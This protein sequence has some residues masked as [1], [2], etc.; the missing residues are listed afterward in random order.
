[1]FGARLIGVMRLLRTGAWSL[2]PMVSRRFIAAAASSNRN[3]QQESR[4]CCDYLANRKLWSAN[5]VVLD[6]DNFVCRAERGVD[7]Y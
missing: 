2:G 5:G 4:W 1:M 3:W 7:D 6:T